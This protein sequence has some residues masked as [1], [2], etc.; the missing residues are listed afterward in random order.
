MAWL[1]SVLLVGTLGLT[2]C[3]SSNNN[4]TNTGTSATKAATIAATVAVTA[5]PS[6]A[7]AQAQLCSSLSALGTALEPLEQIG[8][9]ATV[10]QVID[11]R[12]A[13]KSAL[14][15]VVQAAKY[16]KNAVATDLQTAYDSLDKAITNIQA[17]SSGIL[18]TAQA[19]LDAASNL[20][21]AWTNLKTTVQC[22]G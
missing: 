12:T 13:I 5:T 20:R 7:Q 16:V 10:S 8:S 11:S 9:G 6:V 21:S 4:N 17:G 19:I 1:A 22:G 14:D 15:G 18:Q 2:A 3:S